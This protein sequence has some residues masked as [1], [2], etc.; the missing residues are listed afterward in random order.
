V[1]IPDDCTTKH[2]MWRNNSDDLM[3]IS[4]QLNWPW[5][6][7]RGGAREGGAGMG[8]GRTQ[9][10]KWEVLRISDLVSVGVGRGC[11]WSGQ[12]CKRIE[13]TKCAVQ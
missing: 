9:G 7:G 13:W 8:T 2:A 4:Q 10:S 11:S 3:A 1:E 12:G 5:E 6:G